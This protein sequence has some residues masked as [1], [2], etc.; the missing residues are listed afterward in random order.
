[1]F[2]GPYTQYGEW[3]KEIQTSVAEAYHR[4]SQKYDIIIIEGAGSPAEI[5]VTQQDVANVYTAKLTN[6]PIL[7][8]SDIHYGGVFTY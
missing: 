6:A 1:M 4:L 5:N 8:V 2:A 3:M 7:L